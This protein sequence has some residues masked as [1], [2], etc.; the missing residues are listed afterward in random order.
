MGSYRYEPGRV[1]NNIFANTD[2]RPGRSSLSLVVVIIYVAVPV[3][4]HSVVMARSGIH[5]VLGTM[6][7]HFLVL[8]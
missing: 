6:L 7:T 8:S 4:K 1:S 5:A 3:Y 2:H